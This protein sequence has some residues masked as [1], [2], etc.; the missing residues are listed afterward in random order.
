M[1]SSTAPYNQEEVHS[2]RIAAGVTAIVLSSVGVGWVGAHKFMLGY[3]KEG[4]ISLLVSPLCITMVVFNIIALIE[5]ILYL[6]K[7]DEE[8]YQTYIAEKRGWF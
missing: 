4:L 8:F 3:K 1:D 7:S 2:Q 6:T 5:G